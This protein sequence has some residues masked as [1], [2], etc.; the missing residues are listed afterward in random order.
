MTDVEDPLNTD[1]QRSRE[2]ARVEDELRTWA[3]ARVKARAVKIW[4]WGALVVAFVFCV[5][6]STFRGGPGDIGSGAIG[7]FGVFGVFWLIHQPD[8]NKVAVDDV[9]RSVV[10]GCLL[11]LFLAPLFGLL[12][13]WGQRFLVRV[14]ED[15]WLLLK[16]PA[17]LLGSLLVVIGP[18]LLLITYGDRKRGRDRKD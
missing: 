13:Y 3:E 10:S 2:S 6:L 12:A 7:A 8:A 14:L 15:P 17:L 4:Y 16:T 18:L 5:C 9:R 1:S 11:V